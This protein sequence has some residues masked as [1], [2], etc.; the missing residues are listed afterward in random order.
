MSFQSR[1]S[2]RGICSV[3]INNHQTLCQSAFC[4]HKTS[5]GSTY[6]RDLSPLPQPFTMQAIFSTIKLEWTVWFSWLHM[7]VSVMWVWPTQYSCS[8][9]TVWFTNVHS[10]NIVYSEYAPQAHMHVSTHYLAVIMPKLV[11]TVWCESVFCA[12]V[13][14]LTCLL[15]LH[16][17]NALIASPCVF[18]VYISKQYSNS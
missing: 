10:A 1:P 16:K 8:T 17:Y 11:M 3:Y 4:H 7:W 2:L 15:L 13:C 18:W 6:C 9:W 5:W 12:C 14:T